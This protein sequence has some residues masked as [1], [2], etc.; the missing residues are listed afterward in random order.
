MDAVD[1]G[2]IAG[3]GDDAATATSDDDRPVC[4]GGVVAL[5]N[6]GIKGVA[7]NMCNR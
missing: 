6:G 1:A 3:S 4:D 5:L 2:Y 7:I